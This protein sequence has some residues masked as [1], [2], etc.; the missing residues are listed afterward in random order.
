MA[1]FKKTGGEGGPCSR[2]L[3]C[4]CVA[5]GASV[6]HTWSLARSGTACRRIH[7]CFPSIKNTQVR[8]ALASLP[9]DD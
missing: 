1:L 2:F 9:P 3:V 7:C 6:S 5:E 4:V 8:E